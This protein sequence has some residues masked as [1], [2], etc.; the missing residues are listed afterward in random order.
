MLAAL[1]LG[2]AAY[3][4]SHWLTPGSWIRLALFAAPLAGAYLWAAYNFI[5]KDEDRARVKDILFL[6]G[7]A[8][9]APAPASSASA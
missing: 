5:L 9:P 6:R 7:A 4:A 2:S 1:T 3:I 8:E